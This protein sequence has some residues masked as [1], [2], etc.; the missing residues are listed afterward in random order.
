MRNIAFG[1]LVLLSPCITNAHIFSQ[2]IASYGEN[3]GDHMS[4]EKLA[5]TIELPTVFSQ[6]ASAISL[7]MEHSLQTFA[8]ISDNKYAK[9]II[10]SNQLE[11]ISASLSFNQTWNKLTDTRLLMSRNLDKISTYE[12]VAVGMSRWFYKETFQASIDLSQS[13][14][15]RPY[16]ETINA[17]METVYQPERVNSSGVN[18]S[19]RHLVNPKTVMIYRGGVVSS[20]DRPDLETY[21]V[22][23][24]RFLVSTNGAIHLNIARAI[25]QG[26]IGFDTSYGQ[27]VGNLAEISYLH[28]LNDEVRF[29]TGYRYYREDELTREEDRKVITGSDVLSLSLAYDLPKKQMS[30]AV[31]KMSI[32]VAAASYLTNQNSSGSLYELGLVTA[33]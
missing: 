17:N 21:G 3:N 30:K 27:V 2:R 10:Q 7:S 20:T 13:T 1:L 33:L 15:E 9:E 14:L 32:N 28:I 25:N 5:A 23:L 12:S 18:L 6:T 29:K 22:E 4:S 19:L 31:K 8:D 11:S 26:E 16:F 24:R